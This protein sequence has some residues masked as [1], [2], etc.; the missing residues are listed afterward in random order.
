MIKRTT[1]KASPKKQMFFIKKS[2]LH[3]SEQ[4]LYYEI[5]RQLPVGYFVFPDM[6]VGDVVST[7]HG[8]G[9]RDR[10]NKILPRHIDFVIANQHF[11]P[12]I[13]IELNGKSHNTIAQRISDRI[14]KGV[15]EDAGLPLITLYVGQDFVNEIHAVFSEFL[16]QPQQ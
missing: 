5:V 10:R 11:M 7:L 6:R 16:T 9:Y 1:R 15:L 8:K 14:K 12:I 13:A 3:D 4:A 2:L